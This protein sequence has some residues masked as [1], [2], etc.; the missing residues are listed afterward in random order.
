MSVIRGHAGP[1]SPPAGVVTVLYV[2][3]SRSV[4]DASANGLEERE[5]TGGEAEDGGERGVSEAVAERGGAQSTA[6]AQGAQSVALRP[7]QLSDRILQS[8]PLDL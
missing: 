7:A 5:R 3:M 8:A 1:G 4:N 2:L 6:H